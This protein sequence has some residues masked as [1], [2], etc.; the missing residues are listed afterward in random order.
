MDAL[1]Q[2]PL[3]MTTTKAGIA[4]GTTTT[5]TTANTVLYCLKGKA[6]TKAAASN[7][8]TPTTDATTAAAFVALSANQGTVVVVGYDSSGNLKASQGT[9]Q[10]LD[11]SGAFIL[12]PQF[13]IVPDTVCPF[14]YIVL[15]AGSTLSGTWTFGSSNLSSVTGMTYTFVDVMTLADRPQVS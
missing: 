8:A 3:T 12:A 6:Y 9:V 2:V 5:L 14:G 10:A 4:A 1:S 15:K 7:A 13:P 11:T